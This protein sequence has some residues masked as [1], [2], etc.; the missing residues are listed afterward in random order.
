MCS[1]GK[2]LVGNPTWSPTPVTSAMSILLETEIPCILLFP[3]ECTLRI[4]M[5]RRQ[6]P[7]GFLQSVEEMSSGL[8]K[9]NPAS[10]RK[11]DLNPGPP[12]YMSSTLTTITHNYKLIPTN[13]HALCVCHMPADQKLR[14]LSLRAISHA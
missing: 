1:F 10:G 3:K 7:D 8:L 5:G 9:T 2:F 13:S 11:E 12:D 14:S 6:S 4:A